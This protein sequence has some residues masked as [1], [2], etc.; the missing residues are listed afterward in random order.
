MGRDK[1]PAQPKDKKGKKGKCEPVAPRCV[2]E[3]RCECG[4]MPLS[5]EE[6]RPHRNSPPTAPPTDLV[7]RNPAPTATAAPAA[8]LADLPLGSPP[9]PEILAEVTQATGARRP[10]SALSRMF[11]T[12]G[13]PSVQGGSGVMC[14]G[15]W[16]QHA[17]PKI[18]SGALVLQSARHIS[19]LRSV[20]S[21]HPSPSHNPSTGPACLSPHML[22]KHPSEQ[23]H[24]VP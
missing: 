14:A 5:E 7:Q 21:S 20:Q 10:P 4:A 3:R 16:K 24:L 23:I 22:Q 19:P 8:A 18:G 2:C 9:S 12:H 1:T 17:A 15:P 13:T 6:G 11:R